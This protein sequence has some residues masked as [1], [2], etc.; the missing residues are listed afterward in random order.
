MAITLDYSASMDAAI[1]GQLA[2]LSQADIRSF[3]SEEASAEIPFGTAV[4]QGTAEKGALIPSA[5]DDIAMGVLVHSHATEGLYDQTSGLD[6]KAEL[7]ILNRGRVW[8][9]AATAASIGDRGFIHYTGAQKGRI[10]NTNTTDTVLDTSAQI[11]FLTA[12]T[13][14]G[15]LAVVE[16]DFNAEQTAS[17]VTPSA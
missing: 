11:R 3:V 9:T 10:G 12:S 16:V 4:V 13:E 17:S 8:V 14:A 6:P 7:N 5:Y 1:A 15:D 2:D